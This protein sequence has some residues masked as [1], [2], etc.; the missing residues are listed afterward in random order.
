[1]EENKNMQE[2]D[3]EQLEGVTGGKKNQKVMA[4][5][6]DVRIHSEPGTDKPV[7]SKT[8]QGAIANYTGDLVYV[9][10]EPW[11]KVKWNGKTGWILA[12]YVK[13]V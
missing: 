13:I 4:T 6:P 2:L 12:K 10:G 11:V 5:K 3:I 7:V 8:T 1:M 9:K